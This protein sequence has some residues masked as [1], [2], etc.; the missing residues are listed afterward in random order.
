M[1]STKLPPLMIFPWEP[2]TDAELFDR[3]PFLII[4]RFLECFDRNGQAIREVPLHVLEAL[5]RRFICVSCE[6]MNS[7]DKAFGGCVAQQ[8]NRL[9]EEHSDWAVIFLLEGQFE[10][11]KRQS[12]RDKGL[13][14]ATEV[15]IER[16]AHKL[17]M[18]PDNVRRIYKKWCQG[19]ESDNRVHRSKRPIE[20][21]TGRR[22]PTRSKEERHARRP[23]P[24]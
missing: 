18:K 5:A 24:T 11:A 20:S 7:I 8:R 15:A 12:R 4:S 10:L 23:L 22:K 1:A 9:R 21:H 17:K 3:T 6:E 19:T 2:E 13:G 14:T 16:V